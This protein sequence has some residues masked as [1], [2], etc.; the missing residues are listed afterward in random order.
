MLLWLNL[1]GAPASGSTAAVVYLPTRFLSG[2]LTSSGV[3][4]ATEL[5]S[6]LPGARE[7]VVDSQGLMNPVWYRFLDQFVN[8]FAGGVGGLK[9]SDIV[10]SVEAAQAQTTAAVATT[11]AIA[12]QSQTNAEALAAAVQVVQGASLAGSNQI[13]PVLLSY[14]DIP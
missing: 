11:Q 9:L 4:A 6:F 12:T 7:K 10:A 14:T 13:P 3:N 2:P 1:A 8:V 5:R